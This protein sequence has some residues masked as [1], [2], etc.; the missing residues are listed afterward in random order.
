MT[1][2]GS[3]IDADV[4]V[5]GGGPAG[6]WA[7]WSAATHGARV[8]LV[9]KG[10]LGSSGATAPGG[11][12]LLYLP[13]EAQ[14]R[15]QAVA[16]RMAGG[17]QLSEP[18]W[19]HRV[20]D[21]VYESLKLV[22]QWGYPF[23]RDENGQ[24][25]RNHLQGPEYMRLMRRVVRRAGVTVLDQSPALELLADR[26]GI[27]GA[28]GI[29][30]LTGADWTIRA[31]AV[32]LASGG[33]AFLSKSLG[34]NVLTGDGL[35]M[36][37]ESGA[38]LSGMEFSRSYGTSAEYSTVTRNRLLSMA[39]ITAAD[40][41]V[42]YAGEGVLPREALAR[43]LLHGPVHAVL[44]R[45][46]TPEKRALLRTSH[47]V[48]FLPYDRCGID[49]FTQPFPLTLRF[50][51]TVRGTG[52]IRLTGDGCET[53]VP[54]L[55]AAGDAASRERSHG[56]Q[57]GGGAYNASWAIC[58]GQWAGAAAAQHAA[59][60]GASVRTRRLAPAGGAGIRPTTGATIDTASTVEAVQRETLPLDVS[61]FRSVTRLRRALTNT[62]ALWPAVQGRPEPGVRGRV[63]AREAAAMVAT[64][65]W[66][67]IASLARTET[68]GM[69][70][71]AEHPDPDPTQRHR[72]VLA[73]VDRITLRTEEVPA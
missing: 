8:V 51:G 71:L 64:A 22:E 25:L 45:A 18:R 60:A 63:R 68:R 29:D 40:G 37:A 32:I 67:H 36:A 46:D 20:L 34:C 26:D 48:F 56:G 17:G 65:R 33:C 55:Y 61:Y 13:P 70:S 1:S 21:R 59:S 15:E 9:D 42:L 73:G 53:S 3:V 24:P 10:Y 58:S 50:E 11:T 47:A 41:R 27:G 72:L 12:N 66:M 52:G 23:V 57:S 31:P 28:R 4:L 19:I 5:V 2:E 69:H 6:A 62:E 35:L 49:P 43:A 7:A 44:H 30:R 39:T 38:E 16:K 54:G 14:L